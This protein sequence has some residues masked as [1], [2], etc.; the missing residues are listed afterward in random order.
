MQEVLHIVADALREG[1]DL[2]DGRADDDEVDDQEGAHDEAYIAKPLD[3][4]VDRGGRREHVGDRGDGDDD[5]LQ[6]QSVRDAEGL[7][8][9]RP[10]LQAPLT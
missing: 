5:Q 6:A 3:A 4:H 9:P 1:V 2:A 10:D 7:V 8:E